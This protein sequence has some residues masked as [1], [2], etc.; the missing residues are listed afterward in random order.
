MIR[1]SVADTAHA[2]ER[3]AACPVVLRRPPGLYV[4]KQIFSVVAFPP[5]TGHDEVAHFSYI[6]TVATE[7][8]VPVLTEDP[9]PAKLAAYRQYSLDWS[10]TRPAPSTRQITR[11]C[12]T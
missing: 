8:R 2:T 3:V 12:I 9:L 5:F 11:P 6:R 10:E 4:A 1:R 7:G